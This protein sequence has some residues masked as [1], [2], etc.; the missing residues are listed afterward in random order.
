MTDVLEEYIA[1][2]K[3]LRN[4]VESGGP[5]CGKMVEIMLKAVG[6][7]KGKPWCAAYV[8]YVGHQA[9]LD[10][11]D[12]A[13]SLWPLPMTGGCAVLGEFGLKHNVLYEEPKRGDIFLLYFPTL[14]RFA[15]TGIVLEPPGKDGKCTTIE[16][17]TNG[18]GGRE[19]YEVALRTRT[20]NTEA[21]SRFLRW[22]E[23]VEKD[24]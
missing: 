23:L 24:P 21:G 17:N 5:N 22:S 20:I 18:N 4:V 14:K 13:K 9:F 1:A 15:H 10:E 2:A 8:N 16:G 3:V 12:P 7:P 11:N 6:L 19:G